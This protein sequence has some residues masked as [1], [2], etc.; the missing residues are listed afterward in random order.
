LIGARQA[1]LI[2]VETGSSAVGA[3]APVIAIRVRP[4]PLPV[5][6][7]DNEREAHVAF[8]ATLGESAIWRDY[9]AAELR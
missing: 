1:Q 2:L 9:L 5:R 3:A 8:V 6:L 4:Q 7:T